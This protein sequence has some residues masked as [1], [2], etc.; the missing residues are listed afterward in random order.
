MSDGNNLNH[1]VLESLDLALIEGTPVTPLCGVGAFV[2]HL[3]VGLGGRAD[4]PDLANCVA[5]DGMHS[6]WLE[7][8]READA[9]RE[10]ANRCLREMR[11]AE[12]RIR[13]LLRGTPVSV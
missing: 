3:V 2:P 7:L 4:D 6:R 1:R 9:W 8:R 11:S 13:E 12:R 10:D 5:C